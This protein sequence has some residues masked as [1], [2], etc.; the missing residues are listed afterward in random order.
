MASKLR[1][2]GRNSWQFAVSSGT[3]IITDPVTGEKRRRPVVKW[4]TIQADSKAEAE[5]KKAEILAQ[6]AAG[7]YIEPSKLRLADFLDQYFIPHLEA[8]ERSPHT[9]ESY[10][11]IIVDRIKPHLG[12]L[13]LEKVAPLHVERFLNEF[14]LKNGRKPS[15]RTV[16]YT[17]AVLHRAFE[18]AREMELVA[19]NPVTKV[20]PPTVVR[21]KPTAFTKDE[22]NRILAVAPRYRI[23]ALVV[24]A[25]FAGARVGEL[26]GLRWDDVDFQAGTIT[27]RRTLVHPGS[28]RD[29]VEPLFKEYTKDKEIRVIPMAPDVREALAVWR[30]RWVEERLKAGTGYHE[31]FNLVFPTETG[32]PMNRHN[33]NRDMAAL[34]KAAGV[35]RLSI[36][37]CRHTF[38]TRLLDAGCDVDVV[39]KLL[40]DDLKVV[41]DFY[42]GERPEAKKAAVERLSAYL[43]P[44]RSRGAGT[45]ETEPQPAQAAT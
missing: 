37:K 25:I 43:S 39:A 16:E 35:R 41:Q 42:L 44:Q 4:F 27:L 45:L 26:L 15:A 23:G 18:Y 24:T 10:K 40:G 2:K 9:I 14:R 22:V 30:R 13:P 11:R 19:R 33:V 32:W 1:K 17:R 6:L 3:T 8:K 7:T 5:A 31:R 20:K 21:G 34:L 12:H 28:Q 29:G 38:A 36:H